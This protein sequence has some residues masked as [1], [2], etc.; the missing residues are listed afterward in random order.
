MV[1]AGTLPLRLLALQYGCHVVYGEEIIDRKLMQCVREENPTLGTIDFV[2]KS[3][4]KGEGG[5]E[6]RRLV[7]QTI[8]REKEYVI[9]QMGTRNPEWVVQAARVVQHDVAAIDLNMVS[10]EGGREGGTYGR[11][12]ISSRHKIRHMLISTSVYYAFFYPLT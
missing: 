6:V 3:S 1:R 7:F 8:A 5:K 12:G 9:F 11:S 4:S 10:R 2:T